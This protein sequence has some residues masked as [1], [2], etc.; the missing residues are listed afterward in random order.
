MVRAAGFDGVMTGDDRR[1]GGLLRRMARD[2][3]CLTAGDHRSV[4]VVSAE[5]VTTT[6]A[7]VNHCSYG[8]R[9]VFPVHHTQI[10]S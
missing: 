7:N 9:W 4:C 1:M 10:Y 2:D 6:V 3:G 8:I 5:S